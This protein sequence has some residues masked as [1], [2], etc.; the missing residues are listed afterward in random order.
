MPPRAGPGL[1][2]ELGATSDFPAW[3]AA[4]QPPGLQGAAAK[5]ETG[6]GISTKI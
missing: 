4:T 2:Q 6:R 1:S 3:A 5:Q